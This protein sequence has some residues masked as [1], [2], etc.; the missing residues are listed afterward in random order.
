MT[1]SGKKAG[2]Y[3][4]F[5]EH[6]KLALCSFQLDEDVRVLL[7]RFDDLGAD[8]SEQKGQSRANFFLVCFVQILLKAEKDQNFCLFLQMKCLQ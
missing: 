4:P 6:S 2:P 1:F 7:Q 3:R 8:E 5:S